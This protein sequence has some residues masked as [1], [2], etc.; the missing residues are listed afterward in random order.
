MRQSLLRFGADFSLVFQFPTIV[1]CRSRMSEFPG[2]GVLFSAAVGLIFTIDIELID[3]KG[4]A[5][6]FWMV[7]RKGLS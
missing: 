1:Y 2:R 4:A 6:P 7:S 3:Q 5:D